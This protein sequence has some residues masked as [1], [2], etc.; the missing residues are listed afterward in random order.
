MQGT[1]TEGGE[2]ALTSVPLS[3][4]VALVATTHE[5]EQLGVGAWP[6]SCASPSRSTRM[7]RRNKSD[8]DEEG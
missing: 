4:I 6:G 8:D 1:M 3:V 5:H 7:G 2:A